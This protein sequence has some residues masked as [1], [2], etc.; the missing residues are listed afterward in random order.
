MASE[1]K[2]LECQISETAHGFDL[3]V[4]ITA[5]TSRWTSKPARLEA[6][7]WDEA[8]REA[9]FQLTALRNILGLS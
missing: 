6:E 7:T 3:V 2:H 4:T 5:G 1:A 8:H 9:G